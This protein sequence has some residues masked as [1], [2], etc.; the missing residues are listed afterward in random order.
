MWD[1]D[2][3]RQTSDGYCSVYDLLRV[4]DGAKNPREE[5]RRLTQQFPWLAGRLGIRYMQFVG[6][7]ERPTPVIDTEGLRLLQYLMMRQ[8]QARAEA[9]L[10]RALKSLGRVG[11][12]PLLAHFTA[13]LAMSRAL[14]TPVHGAHTTP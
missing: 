13:V 11:D 4:V 14:R 8:R 6:E 9:H 1:W 12:E 7:G 10:A 3:I 2:S 5:W